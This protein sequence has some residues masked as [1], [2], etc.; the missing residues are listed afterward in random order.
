MQGSSRRR[1][2]CALLARAVRAAGM[3]RRRRISSFSFCICLSKESNTN[4]CRLFKDG[5]LDQFFEGD[6]E[7][8][9]RTLKRLEQRKRKYLN[10]LF[11]FVYLK[12]V[13][14]KHYLKN[15]IQLQ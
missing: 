1:R 6:I 12:N 10:Y 14:K 3:K 15:L 13:A 8:F 5:T 4:E 7:D 9:N 2:N 11:D